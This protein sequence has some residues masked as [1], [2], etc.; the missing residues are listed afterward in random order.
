MDWH[1]SG[2]S[3][4]R[5]DRGYLQEY[6]DAGLLF[7]IIPQL[8]SSERRYAAPARAAERAPRAAMRLRR[9]EAWLRIFVVRCSLPCDPPVGGHSCNRGIIPRFH[10]AVSDYGS[11]GK[12]RECFRMSGWSHFRQI[13]PLATARGMSASLQSPDLCDALTLSA[14]PDG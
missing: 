12:S 9:R 7:R 4:S 3:L 2:R 5:D 10:R 13:G 1:G 14:S 8:C 11:I 6:R